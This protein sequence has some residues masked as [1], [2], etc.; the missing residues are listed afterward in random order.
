MSKATAIQFIH[1]VGGDPAMQQQIRGVE[2]N[3]AGLIGIAAKDGYSFT[4]DEWNTAVAEL[5]DSMMGE[6]SDE[7]LNNVAGGGGGTLTPPAGL[8]SF[9]W[10]ASFLPA[11]VSLSLYRQP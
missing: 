9:S 8:N 11:H 1:K 5:A 6:I 3:I 2:G 10:G 7:D 4:G